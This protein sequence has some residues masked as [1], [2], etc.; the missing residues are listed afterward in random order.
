MGCA[1]DSNVLR[2]DKAVSGPVDSVKTFLSSSIYQ[3]FMRYYVFCSIFLICKHLRQIALGTQAKPM[4]QAETLLL[5]HM[6]Y[7]L[8]PMLKFISSTGGS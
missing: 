5:S 4:F 6:K 7:K 1:K 2:S 8:N 3:N